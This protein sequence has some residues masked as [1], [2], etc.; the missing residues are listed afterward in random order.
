MFVS[1]LPPIPIFPTLRCVA[2]GVGCLLAIAAPTVAQSSPSPQP[3]TV[4]ALR[5]SSRA[6]TPPAGSQSSGGAS[7]GGGVRGCGSDMFALAPAFQPPG[8]TFSEYPTFMWYLG[9]GFADRLEFT[10]FHQSPAGETEIFSQA[11]A[12][13]E[14]GYQALTLP[15]TAEPLQVGETYRWQTTLYCDAENDQAI[16]WV[17]AAI[18]IVEPPRSLALL[19]TVAP[20]PWQKGIR[21]A[22]AGYWY[23]A[24]SQVYA[25]DTVE[26]QAL[27]QAL[28]LDIADLA[29]TA[30]TSAANRWSDRLRNLAETP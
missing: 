23:D 17:A 8:Q 27:R 18:T 20:T 15:T 16:Q 1:P 25:T 28:L 4:E 26:G 29:A 12:V 13:G 19:E 14:A 21:F 5:V 6:Y 2:G 24:L 22:R 10:L 30:D 3:L 9:D 7:T 11:I